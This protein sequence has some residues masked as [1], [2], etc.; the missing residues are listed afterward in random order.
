MLTF[1]KVP[2]SFAE[3]LRYFAIILTIILWTDLAWRRLG[4]SRWSHAIAT[5]G[6]RS[7]AVYVGHVW[8]VGICVAI[9]WQ[10]WWIGP[11]QG[12]MAI[13]AISLLYAFARG[14]DEFDALDR[15]RLGA[16]IANR[17]SLTSG[18]GVVSAALLLALNLEFPKISLPDPMSM[19]FPP[20]LLRSDAPM[21]EANQSEFGDPG[22]DEPDDEATPPQDA[23]DMVKV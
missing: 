9:S 7:L 3:V 6:R 18:A 14:L 21:L 10:L 15:N 13:G 22:D 23:S 1:S 12:L 19:A 4:N 5:M 2:L 8:V 16:L 20:M 17:W 11:A